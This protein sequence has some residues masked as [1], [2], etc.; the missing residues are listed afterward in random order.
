MLSDASDSQNNT[1]ALCT[2]L[3]LD[4]LPSVLGSDI[5]IIAF[6]VVSSSFLNRNDC[7]V[8]QEVLWRAVAHPWEV[9]CK[10]AKAMA[11]AR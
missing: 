8:R 2:E 3:W 6:R 1:M 9:W 4:E 10:L 11:E 7:Q 5:L